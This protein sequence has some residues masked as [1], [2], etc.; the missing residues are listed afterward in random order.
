MT[1]EHILRVPRSDSE[2]DFVLVKVSTNGSLPLDLK[3]LATEGTNPYICLSKIYTNLFTQ[4][5]SNQQSIVK[6]TRISK[7]RAKHSPL[8][9]SLWETVLLSTLLQRR[10]HGN[11]S[12]TEALDKLELI[13]M[14]TG[15]QVVLIFR[16]NISGITQRLGEITLKKDEDVEID[17]TAWA[18]SAVARANNLEQEIQDLNTKYDKHSQIIQK[19]NEQLEDLIQAKKEHETALLEKFRELLNSK[20]LKIRDQ[21]RLLAG[22]KV[23]AQKGL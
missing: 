10:T 17:P 8:Q 19:L 9:D 23:D 21:Q 11:P 6:H 7:L 4:Q 3:L 13:A 22:A 18:G 12:E 16:K 2:G 5:L 14:I 15:D 1:S 20:K